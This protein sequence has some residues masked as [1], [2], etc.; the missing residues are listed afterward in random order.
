M[1]PLLLSHF[2][3][4]YFEF[5]NPLIYLPQVKTTDAVAHHLR[6]QSF[7]ALNCFLVELCHL[8][9]VNQF[10]APRLPR[11]KVRKVRAA[12][13]ISFDMAACCSRLRSRNTCV[14]CPLPPSGVGTLHAFNVSA[15]LQ[16]PGSAAGAGGLNGQWV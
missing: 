8:P 13:Y 16:M 4:L 7:V 15:T 12:V 5:G 2:R 11:R 6:Q 10:V 14:A 9:Q 1:F 3:E